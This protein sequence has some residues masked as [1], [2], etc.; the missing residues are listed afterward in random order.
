MIDD[1]S[2]VV[3]K[4]DNLRFMATLFVYDDWHC[5]SDLGGLTS[6]RYSY[7]E[8]TVWG[9]IKQAFRW[10]TR[11]RQPWEA[12]L[13]VGRFA[14]ARF[15]LGRDLH[16]P[17]CRLDGG[18]VLVYWAETAAYVEAM[19]PKV[20]AL[21]AEWMLAEPDNPHALAIAREMQRIDDTRP[22]PTVA[23]L[24][25]DVEQNGCT[26]DPEQKADCPICGTCTCGGD[27]D[28]AA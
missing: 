20:G 10:L 15:S 11:K 8:D 2:F 3:E 28:G 1:E 27:T 12:M 13:G 19:Q 21:V 16:L 7:P 5:D 9:R 6:I 18:N 26:C 25:A 23:E 17:D 14:M 22:R 4:A 24:A